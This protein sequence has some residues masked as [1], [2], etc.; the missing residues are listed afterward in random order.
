MLVETIIVV[1]IIYFI[2][3][4][5]HTSN[6]L[7]GLNHLSILITLIALISLIAILITILIAILITINRLTLTPTRPSAAPTPAWVTGGGDVPTPGRLKLSETIV[8]ELPV[9]SGLHIGGT[10]RRLLVLRGPAVPHIA[11]LTQTVQADPPVEAIVVFIHVH[12]H[13]LVRHVSDV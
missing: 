5:I 1:K 4:V 7:T 8:G 2:S 11:G 10:R 9:A 3:Q 12:V 6:G 13:R